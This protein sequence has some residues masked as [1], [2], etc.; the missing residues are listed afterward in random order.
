MNTYPQ[1]G[2]EQIVPQSPKQ[3]KKWGF[4]AWMNVITLVALVVLVYLSR[5][6]FEDVFANV[7][8]LSF[9]P[10]LL[11]I[12]LKLYNFYT[13]AKMYQEYL[14]VLGEHKASIK[15]LFKAS[16]EMNFV[17]LVFPSGGV[18]GFSYLSLRLRPLGVS[19]AKTTMIQ[20]ARFVLVFLS[21][22][23]LIFVGM[24]LLAV[25]GQASRMTILVGSSIASLT[26]FGTIVVVYVIS[27]RAR[28][29]AFTAFLPKA[30]NYVGRLFH[31]KKRE[32]ISIARVEKVFEELHDD[33]IQIARDFRKLKKTFFWALMINVSE[34]VLIYMA[35]VAHGQWINPGALIIG[36]AVAN[37]AGLVALFGGAG[38][39]E[40]LMTSVMASAGVPA[41]LA[42]SAT[43]L[44][45]VMNIVI[46]IPVGYFLYRRFLKERDKA[47][48]AAV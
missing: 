7:S 24:F 2:V 11:L 38:V 30:I 47:E 20:A 44:Y 22:L 40:F 19:T 15:E 42:L 43:L 33:Y 4:K 5:H 17:N 1:S 41:A 37:F 8:Q 29:K 23:I 45:R 34:L 14:K 13:I 31:S 32:L 25:V 16:I 21:F 9:V 27:N 28:I 18:S 39:Y 35:F 46:F 6:Q 36:Y 48:E 12:P 3:K 26:L 10:L